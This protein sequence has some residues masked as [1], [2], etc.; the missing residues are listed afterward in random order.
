LSFFIDYSS[1]ITNLFSSKFEIS[2]RTIFK[3]LQFSA[4]ETTSIYS[5][6]TSP[7]LI[8]TFSNKDQDKVFTYP[9]SP[10]SVEITF[11]GR[12]I[13]S[14]GISIE[15]VTILPIRFVPLSN[16]TVDL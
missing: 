10:H 2:L 12:S 16:T 11:K 1:I 8:L 6:Y 15:T 13:F 14:V 7:S 3:S 4:Q 5:P 9:I